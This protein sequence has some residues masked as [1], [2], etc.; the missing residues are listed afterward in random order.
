MSADKSRLGIVG[1]SFTVTKDGLPGKKAVFP[2]LFLS[3]PNWGYGWKE[4]INDMRPYID[5]DSINVVLDLK[6]NK[7]NDSIVL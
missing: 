3:P 1:S 7:V 4:L 5:N 2:N 6:L